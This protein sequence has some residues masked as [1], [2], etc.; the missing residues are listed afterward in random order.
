MSEQKVAS[1]FAFTCDCCGAEWFPAKLGRGSASRDFDESLADAKED[2]W[3]AVK[4]RSR[5][6]KEEWEHRCHQCV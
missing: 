4:V 6:G 3:R 2:G 1:G 5:T